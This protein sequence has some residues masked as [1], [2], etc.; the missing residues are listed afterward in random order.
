MQYFYSDL[1]FTIDSTDYLKSQPPNLDIPK[2]FGTQYVR[3]IAYVR[4]V[5][6]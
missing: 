6:R 5:P 2:K 4:A 1:S 3:P